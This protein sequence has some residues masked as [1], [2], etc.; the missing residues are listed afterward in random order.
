MRNKFLLTLILAVLSAPLF[1]SGTQESTA[2]KDSVAETEKIVIAAPRSPAAL[3]ALWLK[4]NKPFENFPDVEVELYQSMEAMMAM[5]Q[6]E[7]VDFML[8]PSN[9][10]AILY[11]KGFNI[12]MLNVFQWGALFLSTTDPDCRGWKDL[13]GK[14]LYVP[15]KGS[16]PDMTTQ[17][18]L[19]S[20]GLTI[21]KDLDVVYSN[22][23]EIAQLLSQGRISYAIDVEPFV[24]ANRESVENYR[25]ISEYSTDWEQ[26]AGKGFKMPGFCAAAKGGSIKKGNEYLELFNKGFSIAVNKITDNP[27]DSGTIANAYFNANPA[28]IAKA[29]EGFHFF[30]IQSSDI[31]PDVQKYF[32]LLAAMKP[33]VIGGKIPEN[34][35]FHINEK[36]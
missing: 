29:I 4:D 26:L 10:A 6:S 18:F 14:E 34:D 28:L 8:M 19:K 16:V 23:T 36:N 25:I 2:Q 15:A 3:P 13:E 1:S 35:F 31:I 24:T 11:N 5:A 27:Q 32:E 22:H 17:L 9:A 12:K 20:Y 7:E 33:A 30:F 21:G